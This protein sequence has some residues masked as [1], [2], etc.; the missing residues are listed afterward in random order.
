MPL[1]PDARNPALEVRDLGKTYTAG[2][3]PAVDGLSFT[4]SRGE[5]LGLLGGNGAGKTTT[6]AMLLGLLVPS[7]GRIVALGH[8]MA[9]DRL[10]ALSAIQSQQGINLRGV[11]EADVFAA[12]QDGGFTCIEVFFFRAGQNWGNRAYFPRADRSLGAAEVLGETG[13][14][15]SGY[16]VVGGV[17]S[18]VPRREEQ[19]GVGALG[20]TRRKEQH[21]AVGCPGGQGSKLGDD[22]A[23]M[24]RRTAVLR[25]ESEVSPGQEVCSDRLTGFFLL[26]GGHRDRREGQA[27][28]LRRGACPAGAERRERGGGR[29]GQPW[30]R[31]Q[32]R[33]RSRRRP[34]ARAWQRGGCREETV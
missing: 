17:G 3:P 31:G 19:A 14:V 1:A 28:H 8:D 7:A 2:R 21:Q 6:I 16:D 12:H 9:R 34:S 29:M 13:R 22:A 20:R 18:K 33:R 26:A 10:A 30:L 25:R 4:L 32:Q 24:R 5:T 27:V 11:D 23:V 15:G